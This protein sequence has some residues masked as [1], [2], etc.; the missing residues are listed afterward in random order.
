MVFSFG[1]TVTDHNVLILQGAICLCYTSMLSLSITHFIFAKIP[2][3]RRIIDSQLGADF[4]GKHDI[5]S[6]SQVFLKLTAGGTL[7]MAG[8]HIDQALNDYNNR[9]ELVRQ[10]AALKSLGKTM[11]DEHAMNLLLRESTLRE[12]IKG[13]GDVLAE[14]MRGKK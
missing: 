10:A 2:L 5:N 8:L 11:S 6:I 12:G 14:S 4:V 9:L 1:A 3:T 7:S 13:C